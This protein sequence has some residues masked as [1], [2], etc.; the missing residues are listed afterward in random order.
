MR[1]GNVLTI[2]IVLF[3]VLAGVWYIQ[4][5]PKQ[6]IIINEYREEKQEIS[7]REEEITI[8]EAPNTTKEN[9]LVISSDVYS[10][11]Y[12]YLTDLQVIDGIEIASVDIISDV[13]FEGTPEMG[14]EITV[15]NQST[16]IRNYIITPETLFVDNLGATV[17]DPYIRELFLA[18]ENTENFFNISTNA[19]GEATI[20][21]VGTAG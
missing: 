14:R 21:L 7:T 6:P 5:Q 1:N 11:Q 18:L 16:K 17:S 10:N 3:I 4:S 12:A 20:V 9:T 8:E 15:T 19:K 13:S 2:I